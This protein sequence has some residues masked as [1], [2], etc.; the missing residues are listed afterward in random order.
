MVYLDGGDP[1][2]FSLSV[3]DPKGRECCQRDNLH[4]KQPTK[5][6]AETR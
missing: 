1:L 6:K 4:G 5:A 3:A 2:T